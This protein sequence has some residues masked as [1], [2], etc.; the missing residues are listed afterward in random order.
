[1]NPIEKI[2]GKKIKVDLT[3]KN[4]QRLY[5]CKFNPKHVFNNY[6]DYAD[7]MRNYEQS[8]V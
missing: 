8:Q 6:E 4:K 2:M 7:H 5:V 1:M 3:G